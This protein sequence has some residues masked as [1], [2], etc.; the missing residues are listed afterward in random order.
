VNN[1]F[2]DFKNLL[3]R[4]GTEGREYGEDDVDALTALISPERFPRET[5]EIVR[6]IMFII[7]DNPEFS[8]MI[9]DKLKKFFSGYIFPEGG[10]MNKAKK[11]LGLLEQE[12]GKEKDTEARRKSLKKQID[13][14]HDKLM[15]KESSPEA[16]VQELEDLRNRLSELTSEFNRMI[17]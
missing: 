3:Y 2:F 7:D 8:K 9:P 5:R 11:L 16:D 13:D 1:D 12:T 6:D 15:N 4:L 17:G 10:N 14:L